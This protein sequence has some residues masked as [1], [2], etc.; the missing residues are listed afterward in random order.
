MEN[1]PQRIYVLRSLYHSTEQLKLSQLAAPYITT[2]LE[3]A[4][5]KAESSYEESRVSIDILEIEKDKDAAILLPVS[6]AREEGKWHRHEFKKDLEQN[7]YNIILCD[8]KNPK[9][10]VLIN[11][12]DICIDEGD[13]ELKK[14]NRSEGNYNTPDELVTKLIQ[15]QGLHATYLQIKELL[16]RQSR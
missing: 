16:N 12:S 9:R 13:G 1:K 6:W 7:P 2:T 3:A 11:G 5:E 14:M 15:K 10:R 4:L 8:K